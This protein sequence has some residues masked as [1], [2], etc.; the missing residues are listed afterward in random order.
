MQVAAHVSIFH[1]HGL[2]GLYRRGYTLE[3]TLPRFEAWCCRLVIVHNMSM[4]VSLSQPFKLVYSLP[5]DWSDTCE[6]V[7]VACSSWLETSSDQT[8]AF[9]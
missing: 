3:E 1:V 5:S 6:Q 8:A 2:I 7:E 4:I 9:V